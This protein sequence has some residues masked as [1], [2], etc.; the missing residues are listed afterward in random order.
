MAPTEVG[1]IFRIGVLR[2]EDQNIGALQK[3]H[4]FG[5]II[6]RA[7][8]RLLGTEQVRFRRMQ[9]EGFIRFVVRKISD[10]AFAC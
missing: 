7:L 4:Q 9:F 2:I 5:S 8:L 1:L 3:F 6:A 10:R